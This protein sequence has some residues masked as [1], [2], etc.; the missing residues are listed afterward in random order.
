MNWLSDLAIKRPVM[1]TIMLIIMVGMGLISLFGIPRE[2]MPNMSFPV[3]TI[4]VTY[5]GVSPEDMEELV[6]KP[7]EDAI[8]GVQGIEKITS[9]SNEGEVMVVVQFKWGADLDKKATDLREKVSKIRSTLPSDIDE[10][11]VLKLD[12]FGNDN[13]MT[14]NLAGKNLTEVKQVAEDVLKPK[15]ERINGVGSVEIYGGL[16]REILIDV[17]PQKLEGYGINVSDVVNTLKGASVNVPA[18][19]VK[20]GDKQFLVRIMGK[21]ETVDAIKDLV[22]YNKNGNVLRLKEIANIMVTTEDR[23]SY[24]RMNS[25]ESVS[26]QVNKESG[27]N[28]VSISD[29][30]RKKFD[31]YKQSVPKGMELNIARDSATYIKD[32]IGMVS[33]AA[34]IGLVL[35]AIVIFAFLKSFRAT[36]IVCM[37][38]PTSVIF[39]FVLLK[40]RDS[41]LN[42]LSLGGLALGVGRLV[43]DSIVVLENIYRHVSEHKKS[44][45]EAARDGAAEMGLPVLASAL[46]TLAVFLPVI[47]T[48]GLAGEIFRDFSYAVVFSITAS[49]IVA[50]TFVPMISSKTLSKNSNIEKEGKLFKWIKKVYM[51]F[52][53][54]AMKHRIITVTAAGLAFVCSIFIFALVGMEFMPDTDKGEFTITATLPNGLEIEKVNRVA[55][56]IENIVEDMKKKNK[57]ISKY[58]T[59]VSDNEVTVNVDIGPKDARKESINDVMNKFREATKSIPDANIKIATSGM[60]R[61]GGGAA[62]QIDLYGDDYNQLKEISER[63]K[64]KIKTLK[65]VV[66]LKSSFEGGSPEIRIRVNRERAQLY[67]MTVGYIA[68]VV[69]Q[70][71]DSV[72][73]FE[74]Q[75]GSEE[76][77]V[78][79]R[80]SEEFRNSINKVSDIDVP[81]PDGNGS[82]KLSEVASVA[83]GE[84]PTQIIRQDKIKVISLTANNYGV[85]LGTVTKE[86]NKVMAEEKFPQGYGYKFGGDQK[87]MAETMG[88]LGLALLVAIFL[89]YAVMA[90]QFESFIYPAIVLVTLPLG[91]IGV[92]I[93]LFITGFPVSVTVLIGII[94][95]AGIVVNNAI[96]LIDYINILRGRGI[97]RDEAIKTAGKTRLRP[98]F[99]TVA[100]AVLGYVPLAFGIGAGS[101]FY[102]PMAI[103]VAFGLT[104]STV[105]TLIVIPVL[106][107]ITDDLGEWVKSLFKRGKKADE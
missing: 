93:G 81:M 45:M 86:I 3:A 47:F 78:N 70:K 11:T 95:L 53:N 56:Q 103:S 17:D 60:G 63:V 54:A 68:N 50:L 91:I 79:L 20:E 27:G 80:V 19:K 46:T 106:Y 6:A 38:I 10:P 58:I 62:V 32:S 30:I 8:S 26:I 40:Y 25:S 2:L 41:S 107:S 66:D 89:M 15:L 104:M 14:L 83:T 96:I 76:I 84:G 28:T 73:T 77:K 99:M 52:L 51:K 22:I 33:E 5:S 39:T 69:S 48:Q 101:D 67:G 94:M 85:D 59:Q 18:G 92:A 12:V 100:T 29:T 90:A 55:L 102:Q 42:L 64:G 21:L 44:P 49:M 4:Q 16:T 98:I 31:E 23:E 97:A 105:L 61:G 36:L 87:D 9:Y 74:I 34:M 43:D 24:S 13:V 88:A 7:I 65:G 71:V 72:K 82:V 35:A 1:T 75:S 57:F 37:S